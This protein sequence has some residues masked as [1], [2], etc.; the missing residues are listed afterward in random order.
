MIV[1]SPPDTLVAFWSSFCS[2]AACFFS[3][4]FI[5]ACCYCLTLRSFVTLLPIFSFI[6][7]FFLALLLGVLAL[8]S[9]PGVSSN[10]N[11]TSSGPCSL[12]SSLSLSLIAL[13]S[14]YALSSARIA[15]GVTSGKPVS[16]PSRTPSSFSQI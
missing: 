3:I 9:S 4:Y 1:C 7:F 11:S 8:P 5:L 2:F 10:S 15:S 14:A 13:F 12:A 16:E 6:S